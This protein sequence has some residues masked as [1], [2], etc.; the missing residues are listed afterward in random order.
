M[1]HSSDNLVARVLRLGVDFPLAAFEQRILGDPDVLGMMYTGSLGRGGGDRCSDVDITLWLRDEA[2]AKPPPLVLEHYVGWLGEIHLLDWSQHDHGLSSNCFVGPD[3]QQVELEIMGS[4]LATP[5]PYWHGVRVVKDTDDRLASLVAASGPPV[6]QLTRDAARKTIAEAIYHVGFV[7]VQNVRGSYY[8]AMG[9]LCELAGDMYR[10]LANARGREV[11]DVR[12]A[13]RFLCDDELALLY[14]A[15]P[16][17]PEREAIRRA[18]RGLWD[19][20]QYVWAQCENA[21]GEELGIALDRASFLEAIE[22]PYAW[23]RR[24]T[25][26]G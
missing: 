20:I 17:T 26:D 25:D 5:E 8:H 19:W 23:E 3:W 6:A 21:L 9:N 1:T 22:R 12:Y 24:R 13:E 4:H 7:T 2:L 14:A 16:A 15:W 18:A 10:L 11:Y